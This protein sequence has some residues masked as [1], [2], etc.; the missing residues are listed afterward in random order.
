MGAKQKTENTPVGATMYYIFAARER[1]ILWLSIY[2][3]S[4]VAGFGYRETPCAPGIKRLL[5]YLV[6]YV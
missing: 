4:F 1:D 5:C 2:C 6:Q 3:F